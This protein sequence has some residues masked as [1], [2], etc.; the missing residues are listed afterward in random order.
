[1]SK[2]PNLPA[3]INDLSY[4]A[5]WDGEA[6]RRVKNLGW[7]LRNWK[8]V[9]TFIVSAGNSRYDARLIAVM[10][11]GKYYA[12]PF[13]DQT[14]LAHWLDRPVFHTVTVLWFGTPLTIG[15]RFELTVKAISR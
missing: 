7:L 2:T 13:A 6:W 5:V 12:T 11:D 10:R 14:V 15:K 4:A 8:S 1:M 3:E 9:V